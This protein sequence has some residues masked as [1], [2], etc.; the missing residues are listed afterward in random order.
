MKNYFD[1][2]CHLDLLSN[3]DLAVEEARACGVNRILVPS[4]HPENFLKVIELADRYEGVYYTL[5]IHPCFVTKTSSDALKT[6]EETILRCLSDKKFIGIGEIGL[7]FHIDDFDKE[8][9]ESFFHAQLSLAEK[10]RLPVILH[11]RKAQDVVLKYFRSFNLVGGVAHA[12]NGSKQQAKNYLNCGL[13]LGFGGTITF[14]CSRNIRSLL[15][16]VPEQSFVVE[17]DSPDMNPSWLA[18]G[19]ENSP[20]NIVRIF[21]FVSELR[22]QKKEDISID[23]LQNMQRLFP[24]IL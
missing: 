3:T 8:K 16:F 10:Y 23:V 21:D 7:D 9:M 15:K 22:N 17:T 13:L 12:F 24:K 1:T 19:A 18:K 14:E 5:G 11:I 20:K 4:V 2:H 6:L